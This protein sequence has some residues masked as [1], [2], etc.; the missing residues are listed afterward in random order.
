M[1]S[2]STGTTKQW[3]LTDQHTDLVA[4]LTPDGKQVSSST[5]YDPF[6]T[7]TA[8][9]GTTPAIGYQSGWT[10]P[11]SGDV[12]MAA[13]W[14]QPGAGSFNS[15]DTWL[16]D[17]QPSVRGN[18]YAY[19][20][21][22]PLNGTD[23][24]GHDGWDVLGWAISVA[25]KKPDPIGVFWNTWTMGHDSIGDDSCTGRYGMDC[26]EY[27]NRPKRRSGPSN[28]YSTTWGYSSSYTLGYIN[29]GSGGG[30]YAGGS[31]YYAG[32]GARYASNGTYVRPTKPPEAA[33]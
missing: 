25:K 10:D 13:R 26:D 14:Y 32:G 27:F 7:E 23:P 21:D 33:D 4:G 12:N 20:Y 29:Y 28:G 30:Y 31:G 3:A 1:L 2:S 19:A 24:T 5:A 22:G 8:T 18:R 6:G 11:D 15:R 16:L 9:D 17:A